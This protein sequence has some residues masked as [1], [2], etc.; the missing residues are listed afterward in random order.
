MQYKLVNLVQN[1]VSALCMPVGKDALLI[2][3]AAAGLISV[4]NKAR[5]T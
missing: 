1:G 5:A 4:T 3:L 2:A